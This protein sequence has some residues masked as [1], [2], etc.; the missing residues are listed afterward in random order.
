MANNP[1]EHINFTVSNPDALAEQLCRL[2]DWKIRWA[3]KAKDDGYTVHVGTDF[4]YLALYT[5]K[6]MR[7]EEQSHLTL[8][9]LNH[10]GIV[11]DELDKVEQKVINE[12]LVPFNH[13]N[14]EPGRRFYFMLEDNIE[15]EV[16]SYN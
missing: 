8:S 6:D 11:V 15:V 10:V 16:V 2:F 7:I 12:G 14:Y 5:H 3:G 13:G 4:S 1:L 9:H